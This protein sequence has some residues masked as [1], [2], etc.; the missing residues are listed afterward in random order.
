MHLQVPHKMP[1]KD[2]AVAKIKTELIKNR[3]AINQHVQI[4]KE[5]WEDNV[6][7]FDVVLQGKTVTGTLA[8]TET[9]FVLDAKLP[10]MWRLFEKRI[11]AEIAKQVETLK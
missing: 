10:L 5:K 4:N 3:A 6:L 11:E 8:I 2:R 7:T 9:D 1:G